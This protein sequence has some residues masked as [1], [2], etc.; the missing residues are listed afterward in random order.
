[1]ADLHDPTVTVIIATYNR[2]ET[3]KTA[4]E[5][6]LDQDFGDFE[7]WVLGDACTDDSEAV[8]HSFQDTRLRW[9]N[10]PA[11]SGS[12]AQPNN[13]GLRLSRGKY[14]A[15][16]GHD[17]LW[18]PWHLSGLIRYCEETGSDFVHSLCAMIGPH[19][20]LRECIGPPRGNLTYRHSFVPP[21]C[22]LHRREL[23]Q[24]CGGWADPNRLP[25]GVD[26]E[27][28]RRIFASGAKMRFYPRLSVLKFKSEYFP[29]IYA[30]RD[31]SIQVDYRRRITESPTTLE[32][33]VLTEQAIAYARER[34]G[35]D[36]PLRTAL[37]QVASVAL[38]RLRDLGMERWPL[39][40]YLVWR[41]QRKRAATRARRG[42]P[43]R[44]AVR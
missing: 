38:R 27:Y 28:Q 8:I 32:R 20:E 37:A 19:A 3:L 13:E 10:L 2:S 31:D 12:Q 4:I 36:P 21:S 18:L 41:W 17:D 11:N 24:T 22:W 26:F 33:D 44:A 14:L 43:P 42:L 35:G 30:T 29:G 1:M 40:A 7:V 23:V 6:V 15:Y 5:S 9:K 16:L 25:M 39:S 34:R